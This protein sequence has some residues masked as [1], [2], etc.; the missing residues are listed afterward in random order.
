MS[1]SDHWTAEDDEEFEEKKKKGAKIT[2]RIMLDDSEKV[3]KLRDALEIARRQSYTIAMRDFDKLK[4][5]AKTLGITSDV[6]SAIKD[7]SDLQK[8]VDAKK[9]PQNFASPEDKGSGGSGFATLGPNYSEG[10]SQISNP[11]MPNV[12]TAS[13]SEWENFFEQKLIA[14]INE[15]KGR[16]LSGNEIA[17]RSVEQLAEWNL[18]IIKPKG[19]MLKEK[20]AVR[21]RQEKALDNL[22]NKIFI[23]LQKQDKIK[24][25]YSEW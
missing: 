15:L 12:E 8:I 3:Q 22:T 10:G 5:E 16:G 9:N 17:K 7:P 20:S 21:A 11:S 1:E 25:S 2:H 13:V 18:S 24:A 14:K 6:I 23:H 4:N 19:L